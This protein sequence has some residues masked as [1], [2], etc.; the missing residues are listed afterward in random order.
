MD[1][2]SFLASHPPFDAMDRE[3][4][5]HLAHAARRRT[6]VAGTYVLSS[7]GPPAEGLCV[8]REGEIEFR[9]GAEVFDV[10]GPGEVFG[11]PSLITGEHPIF[12]VLAR[13]D[14]VYLLIPSSIAEGLFERP[15]GLRFLATGLRTRAELLAAG[16]DSAPELPEAIG[17]ARDPEKLAELTSD[18][19]RAIR[20]RRDAGLDAGA[21]GRF[22]ASIVD[23]VTA[24]I[25]D[26]AIEELG[27]PGVPWAWLVFGSV[28]RRE[29]GMAPD[30]D[31][32]V[33][34]LGGPDLDAHFERIAAF[35]VEGLTAAGFP[36]CPSDVLATTGGW[37]SPADRWITRLLA[38]GDSPARE[39]FRTTIA[40]DLRK[41]AGTFD[42]APL[43]RRLRDG[44]RRDARLRWHVSRLAFEQRPPSGP[45]GGLV[46]ERMGG[47]RRGV[48]VK[49]GGLLPVTDLARLLDL[50]D[51]DAAVGTRARLRAAADSGQLRVDSAR[52]LEA[53][54]E[55]FQEVRLDHQLALESELRPPDDVIE[56]SSLEPVTRSRLRQAFRIV[57]HIQEGFRAELGGGRLA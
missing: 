22:I 3:E 33:V 56:P 45:F 9:R 29:P 50:P 37:R 57:A 44:V 18:L 51:V 34:W 12:D 41:V 25:L 23:G 19:P 1:D 15:A 28:A 20:H 4:V 24:R 46:T 35:A 36:P 47:G 49:L 27:D 21:I 26:L 42:V 38:P 39:A 11:F 2:A 32:T 14:V 43:T 48:N 6:A 52:A 55:T 16:A 8:V 54:F 5:Q 53:A 7:A 10:L 17:R 40:L 30:Q 13:T 31:H